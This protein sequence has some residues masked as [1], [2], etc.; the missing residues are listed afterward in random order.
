MMRQLLWRYDNNLLH[1]AVFQISMKLNQP[2]SIRQLKTYQLIVK[3]HQE[4]GFNRTYTLW[5]ETQPSL[6]DILVPEMLTEEQRPMLQSD[7]LSNYVREL[8]SYAWKVFNGDFD[9]LPRLNEV[10]APGT[11]DFDTFLWINGLVLSR[12]FAFHFNGKPKIFL[13][14]IIDMYNDCTD[15]ECTAYRQFDEDNTFIYAKRDVTAGEQLTMAYQPFITHRADMSLIIYGF[16]M[17]SDPPLLAAIDRPDFLE[18]SIFRQTPTQDEVPETLEEMLAEIDRC[19]RIL[20]GLPTSLE[21]DE[22][23]LQS[24]RYCKDWKTNEILKYRIARKRALHYRIGLLS[25][26][27]E[28]KSEL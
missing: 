20:D 21:E 3:M 18:A 12:E 16:A 5:W 7:S 2:I 13:M 27:S 24:G 22:A 23:L 1:F 4:T 15:N 28:S 14:P 25:T 6:D 19:K 17:I 26:L 8:R 9:G 11:I 10:I